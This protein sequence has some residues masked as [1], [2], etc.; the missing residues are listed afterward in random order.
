VAFMYLRN[1]KGSSGC[2][3]SLRPQVHSYVSETRNAYRI[4]VSKSERKRPLG[5]LGRRWEDNIKMALTE[6]MQTEFT[7][8]RIGTTGGML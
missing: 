7:S 8:L 3:T 2:H 1:K 4:L 5:D 6:T